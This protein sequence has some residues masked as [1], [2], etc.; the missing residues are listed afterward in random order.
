MEDQTTTPP[1]PLEVAKAALT[2]LRR[3]PEALVSATV[4]PG[5][6]GA[7]DAYLLRMENGE[8]F[9]LNAQL[10]GSDPQF[11]SAL[12]RE[13][14]FYS[15]VSSRLPIRTP[16]VRTISTNE[17]TGVIIL[18]DYCEASPP[19]GAWTE[20]QFIRAAK[21]LGQF[22][23]AFHEKTAA[24]AGCTFLTRR[25]LE[26]TA[27]ELSHAHESWANVAGQERFKDIITPERLG[28]V[29][30]WVETVTRT[31]SLLAAVPQ[32]LIHG[33]CH[34]GNVLTDDDGAFVWAN[35][36]GASIGRGPEDISFFYQRAEFA[37]G[38]VPWDAMISAYHASLQTALGAD[39]P[40][41]DILRAAEASEWAVRLLQ[42]PHYMDYATPDTLRAF[43]TRLDAL[44]AGFGALVND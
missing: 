18:T 5:G 35:W 37:G 8:A 11:T 9:I 7:C 22:H 38:K 31:Q 14:Q 39:I 30:G 17:S 34:T 10:P 16:R 3:D 41:D 13:A 40:F 33:D 42:W 29:D 4:R 25:S 36:S 44:A 43:V 19:A 27:E 1:S 2:A 24:L 28:V 20:A 12:K 6:V 32:T 21:D 15:R 26:V 23:A